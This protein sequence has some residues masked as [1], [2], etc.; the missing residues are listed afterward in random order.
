MPNFDGGLV[1]IDEVH[2]LI[3]GVKNQSKHSTLIY[4]A[5]MKSD[6]KILALTGTPVFNFIWEWPF[7]GN[8]LK[9][10]T[11]TR[12]IRGGEL[13]KEAFMTKFYISDTGEVTPKNKKMFD[14]KLRG[15][16]SYFPGVAGGFY[17]EVIP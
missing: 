4:N 9:P 16:I 10:G 14:I 2:N 5:L 8:L 11:F 7:L 17:P 13:D 12:M 6:C 3:N 15:I 1:I